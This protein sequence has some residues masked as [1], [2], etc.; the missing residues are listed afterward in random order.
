MKVFEGKVAVVTGA[1]G[2]IGRALA[3]QAAAEGMSV[4]IADVDD[5]GLAGTAAQLESRGANVIVIHTDVS[6][7]IAVESLAET[8]WSRLGGAH[9]VFNNAGVMAG[10]LSWERSVEDW[11]WV[12]GVNLWGVING[13]RSFIP[14]LI[15]QGEPAHVVN[16]ASV[17][18]LIA[19]PFLSPYL[20]SKHAVLAVTESAHHELALLSSPIRMS[21][22]CPGAVKT[23]ITDSERIRPAALAK[24][25][26][27]GAAD[28]AFN[29]AVEAGIAKGS[30]PAAIALFVFDA[31]R[32]D[33]FWILPHPEFKAMV[34]KRTQ[35][36]LDESNPVYQQ[37]LV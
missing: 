23:G 12:L 26:K 13:I 17:A 35:S 1:A 6:D 27:S 21:L 33:K 32:Q 10:G 14:R 15:E 9:V 37:D 28:K 34:E 4:V 5:E 29:S 11:Q 30:D 2:G 25:G 19:G 20:A 7:P 36:V 3:E 22:L 18:A 31:L 16:T 24:K 8:A